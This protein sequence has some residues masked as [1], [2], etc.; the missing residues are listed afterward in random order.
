MSEF[1]EQDV[2]SIDWRERAETYEKRFNDY[3][4]EADRRQTEFQQTQSLINDLQ[5]DDAEK[6]RAA[7]QRL[8]FDFVVEEEPADTGA[9]D[10][11][12]ALQARIDAMERAA[13]EREHDAQQAEQQ[14]QLAAAVDAELAGMGLDEDDGD[15]VLARAIA[16]PPREDGLPDLAAAKTQLEARDTARLERYRSSKKAPP[17]ARGQQGTEQKDLLSMTDAERIDYVMAQHDME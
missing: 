7:A 5:S 2:E 8:G 10:P 6:Q 17:I 4:S 16:L 1:D 11:V 12:S 14:T 9:D 15:W 13:Q 3:R